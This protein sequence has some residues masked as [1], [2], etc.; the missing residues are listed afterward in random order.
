M[1]GGSGGR[2]ARCTHLGLRC[3]CVCV[4][5]SVPKTLKQSMQQTMEWSELKYISCTFAHLHICTKPSRTASHNSQVLIRGAAG[6][7]WGTSKS[8]PL[9]TVTE[10]TTTQQQA[11]F[12]TNKHR[13]FYIY[14]WA[15]VKNKNEQA[16]NLFFR[17]SVS[18]ELQ[19]QGVDIV[20]K[21]EC[22]R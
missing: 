10:T 4:W 1:G 13:Y 6:S 5:P 16:L 17:W 14:F 7:W 18:K 19:E 20:K 2:G 12:E 15:H 8:T 21:I 22:E 11:S 3:V 9:S